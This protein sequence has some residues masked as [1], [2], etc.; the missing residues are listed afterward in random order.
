LVWL[1]FLLCVAIILF[2]GTKLARYGDAIAEK[3]GL[4][5]MWIG[6]LFLAII[7]SMPEMAT[8]ISAAALVKLPDL[9]FG[10][11]FGSCLFNLTILALLDVMHRRTPILSK[12]RPV[13][14]LSAGIGLL[15]VAIAALS[16]LGGEKF[17]KG[18]GHV[19]SGQEF[20]GW[21]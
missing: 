3:T 1:K 18:A 11:I 2:A 19:G 12:V 9:T 20:K 4:G 7:T 5:R 8:G 21:D 6:L 17:K 16:I 13:H 15:L 10:T 14:M